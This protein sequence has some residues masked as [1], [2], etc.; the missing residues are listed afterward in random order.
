MNKLTIDEK[1]SI[2][3][4]RREVFRTLRSNIEFTGV[5]N[6]AI[7]V[8][9]CVPGDGKSTVSFNLAR[10]FAD[11]GKKTILIDA[12]MRKSAMINRFQLEESSEE[13]SD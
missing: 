5:D 1:E 3:Q 8:T 13:L 11:S 7:V 12:D 9:S 2:S 6:R 4:A 10:T